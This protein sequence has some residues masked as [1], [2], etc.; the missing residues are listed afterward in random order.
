MIT[1]MEQL[2]DLVKEKNPLWSEFVINFI[3][4]KIIKLP[5]HDLLDI[6]EP[7]KC[8]NAELWNFKYPD[9]NNCLDF[10]TLLFRSYK[11]REPMTFAFLLLDMYDHMI[12]KH[13]RKTVK[14]DIDQSFDEFRKAIDQVNEEQYNDQINEDN[15]TYPFGKDFEDNKNN[16]LHNED[17]QVRERQRELE[18]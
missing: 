7:E 10:G 12:K 18:N 4:G 11:N 8:V 13:K 17:D 5:E 1:T 2:Y 16:G 15:K 6:A 14:I 3:K 9:C